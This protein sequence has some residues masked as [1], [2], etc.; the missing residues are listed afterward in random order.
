[1][2]KRQS[3]KQA[4]TFLSV[5]KWCTAFQLSEAPIT[6]N[7]DHLCMNLQISIIIMIIVLSTWLKAK[8]FLYILLDN[9][10]GFFMELLK[11]EMEEK[12]YLVVDQTSENNALTYSI[13]REGTMQTIFYPSS[14]LETFDK[15][16]FCDFW[17]I[18]RRRGL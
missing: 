6:P 15:G 2:G 8:S 17:A 10:K 14:T 13:W 18:W 7:D 1:M 12:Y 5:T 3:S 16:I 9:S 11:C 4:L